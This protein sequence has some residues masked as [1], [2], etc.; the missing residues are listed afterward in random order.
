VCWIFY[1]NFVLF[2]AR[3]CASTIFVCRVCPFVC[4]R[5]Q[6]DILSSSHSTQAVEV[7]MG[8]EVTGIPWSHRV[9]MEMG[10]EMSMETEMRMKL[11]GNSGLGTK[12]DYEIGTG[13]EWERHHGNWREW[14]SKYCSRT[15]L[16]GSLLFRKHQRLPHIM[17]AKRPT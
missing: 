5:L 17:A 4:F 7:C 8:M 16:A 2:T 1:D 14:E 10:T 6:V 13:W 11:S 3:R 12:S 15:P 9:P